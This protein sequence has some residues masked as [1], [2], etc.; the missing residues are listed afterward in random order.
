MGTM[1]RFKGLEFQRVFL[2]SV[3]DGRVPHQRIEQ[4][5]VTNPDRYR[6]EERRA[7]SLVPTRCR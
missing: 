5:R 3:G 1:H 6:Q 4:Y 7:R 2:T